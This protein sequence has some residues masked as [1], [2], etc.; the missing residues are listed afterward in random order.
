M[1]SNI[2]SI[3]LSTSA[4]NNYH[5]KLQFIIWYVYVGNYASMN[6]IYTMASLCQF[7][8][9]NLVSTIL[10]SFHFACFFISRILLFV[11]LIAHFFGL[12]YIGMSQFLDYIRN[13][14]LFLA[15][16]LL[17]YLRLPF[18]KFI[19]FQLIFHYRM[20]LWFHLLLVLIFVLAW[21]FGVVFS[22]KVDR[23]VIHRKFEHS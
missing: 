9:H 5:P 11:L 13:Q 6:S 1:F 12:V 2:L 18:Y 21:Y 22:W 17:K 8:P 23:V 3:N 15:L 16:V 14:L 7:Y 20:P 4:D 19:Q 10:F